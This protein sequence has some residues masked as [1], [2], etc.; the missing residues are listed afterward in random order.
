MFVS[1]TELNQIRG[2]TIAEMVI[3]ITGITPETGEFISNVFGMKEDAAA[4]RSITDAV[5]LFIPNNTVIP[6][7][8]CTLKS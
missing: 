7:T 5:A 3:N 6:V 1:N 2:S 4:G 8:V